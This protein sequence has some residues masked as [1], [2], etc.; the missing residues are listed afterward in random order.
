MMILSTQ[1][2]TQLNSQR[3][4]AWR[5][6]SNRRGIIYVENI[7]SDD[8][9]VVSELVAIQ[10]L[11]FKKKVFDRDP[12]TGK[13]Y[14]LHVSSNK[15]RQ[16]I[17]GK[18]TYKHLSQYIYFLKTIMNGV[19]IKKTDDT[20]EFL[21][22][23]NDEGV[24]IEHIDVKEKIETDIIKTPA[25]GAIKLTK[26]AIKQFEDRH[27][28]GDLTNPVQSLIRRIKHPAIQKKSLPENVIKHKLKKYG[29]IENLEVWSH[30]SSQIHYVVVRDHITN[31]G[32][33]VTIYKRHPA[34]N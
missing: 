20:D 6:G 7:E 1:V 17:K 9:D 30:D 25:M 2:I 21:P 14:K 33:I 23:I 13:G 3:A 16:M 31:V 22:G 15:I 5:V 27:H 29:T 32:T 24:S 10:Y 34:Y 11:L 26:H 18:S 4:V 12:V 28:A 8:P 19:L